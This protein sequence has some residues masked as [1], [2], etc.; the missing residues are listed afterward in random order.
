MSKIYS[1]TNNI[2]SKKYIGKTSRTLSQRINEHKQ[3]ASG[4]SNN[5]GAIHH[6]ISKYGIDNFS[7]K[8]IEECDTNRENEREMYWIKM[9]Q[10]H[11][12]YGK[13]YNLTKGGDGVILERKDWGK[14][15][16]SKPVSKYD[17]NGNHMEDYDSMGLALTAILGKSKRLHGKSS[18]RKCCNGEQSFAWGYRWSWKDCPLPDVT[19]LRDYTKGKI[20]GINKDG[21][22]KCWQTQDD[23][24]KEISNNPKDNS[25]MSLSLNSQSSAKRCTFGWYLFYDKKQCSFD[26]FTPM[27]RSGRPKGTNKVRFKGVKYNNPDDV[28][29]YDSYLDLK[30]EY[31]SYENIYRNIYNI[32]MGKKWSKCYDR[33]WYKV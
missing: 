16:H 19:H 4:N 18:I 3:I 29:Y 22:T 33:Q 9:L 10:T 5:K 20:Y 25:G 12:Q 26:K 11:V 32:E 7:I 8:C 30:K 24:V 15:I 21:R 28:V 27:A 17:L 23:C 14:H 1:I 6:A 2:N 31:K 13:G